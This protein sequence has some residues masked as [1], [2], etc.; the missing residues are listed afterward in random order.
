MS[1]RQGHIELPTTYIGAQPPPGKDPIG[2]GFGNNSGRGFSPVGGAAMGPIIEHLKEQAVVKLQNTAQALK[3]EYAAKLRGL[4]QS[5][6][7]DLAAVRAEGSTHT[8]PPAE[9]ILRELSVRNTL[10]LR[11]TAEFQIQSEIANAFYGGDPINRTASDFIIR[12]KKIESVITPDSQASERWDRSYKAAYSAKLLTDTIQLL[13]NQSVNVRNF[14]AAVQADEQTRMAADREAQRVATELARLA[15]EAE[16]RQ[17]AAEQARIAAEAEARRVAAEQTRI[18]AEQEA[19]RQAEEHAHKEAIKAANTFPAAG[20]ASGPVFTIAGGAVATTPEVSIAL[21]AALRFAVTS[22]AAAVAAS[23][24]PVLVGFAALLV[25]SRLGNSERLAMSIPLAELAPVQRQERWAIAAERGGTDLPMRIGFKPTGTGIEVFVATTD[26]VK[27]PSTVPVRLATYDAQ[28]N[29]YRVIP[30]NSSTSTLTWTPAVTPGNNSTQLPV[31]QPDLPVYPG[32]TVVPVEGRIDRL[33]A[34]VTGWENFITVFPD[35]SGIPPLYVVF[36]SPYDGA[37]VTG[38]HSGRDFNPD[39]AGGPIQDLEWSSAIISQGGID[40]VKLHT[41]RLAASDA[42]NVMIE[43][44]EKI[45]KGELDFT[46]IDKRYYTHE[47]RE[48]DRFRS[49]GYS[50]TDTPKQDSPAWN[51][52]HT[53]TLEDYKVKDDDS[54][55]YTEEALA[56]ADEQDRKYFQSLLKEMQQ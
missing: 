14:L 25:P 28:L 29:V 23:I 2:G 8:L 35:D 46:D 32:A 16:V 56:A 6:E 5:I 4:P 13:N 11:K 42:N 47:I 48:L 12:A 9:A 1:D 54:L 26:G 21:K 10:I 44:L 39:Q 19:K 22:A 38:E 36:S 40:L 55:L 7:D 30:P 43:R 37:T 20:A 15:A 27:L 51:N 31:A 34:L 17:V 33:P 24:G 41:G 53:A 52:A 50:D 45:L 3:N 49:L 18:A